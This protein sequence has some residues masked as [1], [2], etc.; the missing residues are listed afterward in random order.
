MPS[1]S[2]KVGFE[3]TTSEASAE[4]YMQEEDHLSSSEVW[5]FFLSL[6]WWLWHQRVYLSI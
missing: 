5:R 1:E 2:A 3:H 4:N 6:W